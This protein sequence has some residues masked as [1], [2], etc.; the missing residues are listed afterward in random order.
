MT[1]QLAGIAGAPRL[2]R[3]ARLE[4]TVAQ[5]PI[6]KAVQHVWWSLVL[7][8]LLAVTVGIL[9]ITRPMASVAALALVIAL[10]ALVHG[11]VTMY[12]AFELRP[13]VR[14]W[15]VALLSGAISAAFGVAALYYYPALSLTFA[16]IWTAWWL[17]LGGIAGISTALQER[18]MAMPWGWTMTF[19]VLSV[20]ASAAAF[21]NPPGTLAAL[22][23]LLSAFAIVGGL[24]L[25]V[26]AFRLRGA[27]DDVAAAV[28]GAYPT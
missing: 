18:R 24:V 8:G 22:M 9:I 13:I 26:G 12:H 23:G 15:W 19:G 2:G 20:A 16:V 6:G 17:M 5:T 1:R 11:I 28:H 7:R 25:L 14:H 27:A 21:T 10:W 3:D 4:G